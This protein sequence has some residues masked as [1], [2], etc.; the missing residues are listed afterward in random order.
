ML[1]ENKVNA[2][3]RNA[4]NP[5]TE[6]HKSMRILEAEHS[7]LESVFR[8]RGSRGPSEKRVN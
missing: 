3:L 4:R 1:A 2:K 8:K 7:S 5:S 6:K